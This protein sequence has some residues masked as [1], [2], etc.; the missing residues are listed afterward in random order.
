MG[1]LMIPGP[2]DCYQDHGQR[3]ALNSN[4]VNQQTRAELHPSSPSRLSDGAFAA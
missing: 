1:A 4:A 3:N 2:N